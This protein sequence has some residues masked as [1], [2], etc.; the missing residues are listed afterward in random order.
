MKKLSVIIV[1]YKNKEV[2]INCLDSIK[3]FN[4]LGD[5]LEVIVSDNS[6]D[7]QLYDTISNEYDWIKIIKN[8]NRGFGAGNNR[9]FEIS[10]GQYLLFL[11]P[12]TVLVEPIFKFAT[13]IFENNKDI[14]MFGVQLIKPNGK[15]NASFFSYDRYGILQNLKDKLN[16]KL[17][18]FKDNKMFICGADLFIRRQSFIEAGCFDEK[19]FM[20]KEEADLIKRIKLF[21][22]SKKVA[23]YKNKK[24]IHLEGATEVNDNDKD[25]K[26]A[27]R[28][29]TTDRYYAEKWGIDF[30]K[31]IKSRIS[32]CKFKR[33]I[34]RITFKKEKAYQQ[35]KM[36]KFYSSNLD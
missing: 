4:D 14:A 8:D 26:V 21:A 33:L 13:N 29:V 1:S 17:G 18:K 24:I 15:Q 35:N 31:I 30:N 2:L 20:Y 7:L 3:K 16:R 9:G 32:Y 36:I 27:E 28:L 5:D 34:Y 23:F 10:S 11:N 6:P 19:I 12:D 22:T 25:I